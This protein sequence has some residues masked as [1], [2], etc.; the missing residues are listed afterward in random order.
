MNSDQ[1]IALSFMSVEGE[2]VEQKHYLQWKR[3][4]RSG[5]GYGLR[6]L[7]L[8][9]NMTNFFLLIHN[10]LAHSPS[11]PHPLSFPLPLPNP[12]LFHN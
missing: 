10:S 2:H 12:L 11:L 7:I 5:Q 9:S 1:I 3:V 6:F 8:Y 4:Q